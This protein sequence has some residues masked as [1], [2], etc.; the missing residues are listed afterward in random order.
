M[1]CTDEGTAEIV[2]GIIHSLNKF[3]PSIRAILFESRCI[4]RGDSGVKNVLQRELIIR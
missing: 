2:E 4:G 1:N 3:A